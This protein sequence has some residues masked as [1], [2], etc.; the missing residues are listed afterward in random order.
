MPITFSGSRAVATVRASKDSSFLLR[1]DKT[2]ALLDL[3]A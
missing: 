3:Q 2:H 1:I